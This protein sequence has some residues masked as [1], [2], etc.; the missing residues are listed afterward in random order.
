L[1]SFSTTQEVCA[2]NRPQASAVHNVAAFAAKYGVP[3]IADGGVGNTGHIV[4]ALACG[5]ATVM[6]GSLLAGTDEAPGDYFFSDGVRVK[7][8]RGVSGRET[9][10]R[11]KGT[12]CGRRPA[13][14]RLSRTA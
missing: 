12:Q 4:K 5:A 13:P 3:V 6:M 9:E 10:E 7:K 1:F 8:Y 2:V 11:G 14:A